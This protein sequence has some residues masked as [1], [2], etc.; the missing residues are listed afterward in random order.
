MPPRLARIPEGLLRRRRP[1]A[2]VG[3]AAI[4]PAA[5]AEAAALAAAVAEAAVASRLLL[6]EAKAMVRPG[7]RCVRGA[8]DAAS[9]RCAVSA[10]WKASSLVAIRKREALRSTSLSFNGPGTQTGYAFDFGASD[11][12][13]IDAGPFH[14]SV[15]HGALGYAADG[16]SLT[17]T[18]IS[19][20]PLHD[21]EIVVHPALL[22]TSLGCRAISIDRFADERLG[23]ETSIPT[24]R[25]ERGFRADVTLYEM[26]RAAIIDSVVDRLDT[27]AAD[28][29]KKSAA[30][31][32]ALIETIQ[33]AGDGSDGVKLR[34]IIATAAGVDPV[35]KGGV[36]F[37]PVRPF[38][39]GRSG[40][41]RGVPAAGRDG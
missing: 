28:Y 9:S 2:A 40:A 33:S 20:E 15:V 27:K 18:M 4:L 23:E 8:G 11:G 6:G 25:A 32:H 26:A 35:H 29:L 17:A 16:R 19:A 12:S 30:P 10:A 34:E 3:L 21:L 37:A 1:E 39:S 13:T 36:R 31:A 7:I 41:R 38:Q 22:D 24:A 14:A 5:G